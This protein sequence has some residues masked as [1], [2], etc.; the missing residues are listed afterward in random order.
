MKLPAK[1][2]RRYLILELLQQSQPLTVHQMADE[3]GMALASF[4]GDGRRLARQM[5]I[6]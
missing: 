3:F 5:G 2:T 6:P 4:V 1:H